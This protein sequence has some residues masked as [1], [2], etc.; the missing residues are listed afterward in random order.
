MNIQTYT[1]KITPLSNI[2]NN[3]IIKQDSIY[4]RYVKNNRKLRVMDAHGDIRYTTINKID[5]NNDILILNNRVKYYILS[6]FLTN[7]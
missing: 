4:T 6:K 2:R 5:T 3:I 7:N 1:I